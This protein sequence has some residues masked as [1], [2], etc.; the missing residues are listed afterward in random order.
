[1]QIRYEMS[2]ESYNYIPGSMFSY[3]MSNQLIKCFEDGKSLEYLTK[4]AA[5]V[6]SGNNDKYLKLWFEVNKNEIF[7]IKERGTFDKK[8]SKY[9]YCNKGGEFRKWYGNNDWVALWCKNNEFHRNGA[10][11]QDLLFI[12][13]MTW[14]AVT[15]GIFHAR[16]Y[17]DGFVFDHASPSLFSKTHKKE[18]L[19][20]YIALTNS[21]VGQHFLDVLNP[22]LNTGADTIRKIP[23]FDSKEDE[24]SLIVNDNIK[25]CKDDWDSFE[26]SWDFK[27]HPL[28]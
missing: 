18:K 10:T 8:V 1:M 5:G 16:Y 20:Y 23:V 3:W 13:G 27:K 21:K 12:E 6:S 11:Y 15:T 25:H 7:D 26:T 4:C 2:I 28:I 24:V 17:P 9:A 19:L 22:T 14:S